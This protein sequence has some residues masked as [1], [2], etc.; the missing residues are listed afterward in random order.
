MAAAPDDDTIG[1]VYLA[2]LWMWLP[3]AAS[4]GWPGGAAAFTT[5]A[6]ECGVHEAL[7]ALHSR[8]L[9]QI[10]RGDVILTA[11]AVTLLQHACS[12]V[13]GRTAK[14]AAEAAAAALLAEEDAAA[15]R[16]KHAATK[17]AAAKA[18]K[19]A[20]AAAARAAATQEAAEEAVSAAAAQAA[21]ARDARATEL[22]AAQRE[23]EAPV[24]EAAKGEAVTAAAARRASQQADAMA[25][26]PALQP[27]A[28]SACEAEHE[29]ASDEQLAALFPHLF[30][31]GAP[32]ISAVAAQPPDGGVAPASDDGDDG[33]CVICMDCD[34]TTALVPCGHVLLCELCADKVLC[35][36]EPACPVCRVTTT[37]CRNLV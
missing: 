33:S 6:E 27:A 21:A 12:C 2:Q 19:A 4:A 18:R 13:S 34:R 26:A 29:P 11:D 5:A 16:V 1:A 15:E 35:A 22:A 9:Q 32:T 10:D 36:T 24:R 20:A 3:G 25:S 31:A 14:T 17:K 7:S 28:P 8:M 23:A 30:F 37:G